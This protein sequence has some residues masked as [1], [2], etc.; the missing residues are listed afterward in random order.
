MLHHDFKAERL[1]QFAHERFVAIG[2]VA[3]QMMVY[4]QDDQ[5]VPKPVKYVQQH[6]GIRS[7]RYCY[8]YAAALRQH[9]IT[10]DDFGDPLW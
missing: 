8:A 2:L 5:F 7:A 3:A 9:A 1:R 10:R 4:V 6:D